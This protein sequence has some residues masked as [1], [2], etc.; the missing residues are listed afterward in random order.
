MQYIYDRPNFPAIGV[1]L[2]QISSSESVASDM[3]SDTTEHS[4][5]ELV[6]A[7]LSSKDRDAELW[8]PWPC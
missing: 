7:Q 5:S 1:A 8:P 6:T 2:P 4:A 3:D